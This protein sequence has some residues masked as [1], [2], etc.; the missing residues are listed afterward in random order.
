M[1]ILK[2][3][4]A[5]KWNNNRIRRLVNVDYYGF[6]M[7]KKERR[8]GKWIGG[9]EKEVVEPIPWVPG[10]ENKSIFFVGND[11]LCWRS[12]IHHQDH[13]AFSGPRP[14]LRSLPPP[15]S[16]TCSNHK[17]TSSSSSSSSSSFSHLILFSHPIFLYQ[18][19]L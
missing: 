16:A 9:L 18:F 11:T 14:S 1:S 8:K 4:K 7:E 19:S 2:L 12:M 17:P 3:V 10:Q 6:R 15:S 13:H 5:I